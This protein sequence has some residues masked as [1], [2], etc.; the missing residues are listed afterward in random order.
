MTLTKALT[1]TVDSEF[2]DL[3][4]KLSHSCFFD[5]LKFSINKLSRTSSIKDLQVQTFDEIEVA[6]SLC[7]FKLVELYDRI[8]RVLFCQVIP[9]HHFH[10][11]GHPRTDLI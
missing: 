8:P 7:L 4:I 6:E 5:E 9:L 1:Q 2:N 10:N 11:L 3:S